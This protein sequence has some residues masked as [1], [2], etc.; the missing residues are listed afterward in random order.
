M[1]KILCFLSLILCLT[2]FFISPSAQAQTSELNLQNV[3]EFKV[4]GGALV[5]G[6]SANPEKWN[7][8]TG[9]G[10]REFTSHVDFKEAYAQKPVVVLAISGLDVLNAAN[11]RITATA[12]NVTPRGFDI[13]YKTWANSQIW[14]VFLNWTAFG[15]K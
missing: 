1:K 12:T 14:S 2:T 11:N 5:N 9:T 10:K 3:K 7:L 15:G 8:L 4:Q 13:N 6:Y